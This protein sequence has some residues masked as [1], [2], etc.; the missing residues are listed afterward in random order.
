MIR[1]PIVIFD[2]DGTLIDSAFDIA[3]SIN[4]VRGT[5]GLS[6]LTQQQIVEAINGT[7][8]NLAHY[9]Y[10][11]STYE[12]KH[13]ALFETHYHEQCIQNVALYSH[14]DALLQHLSVKKVRCSVA[15]NAP[16]SFA[17]RMLGH[18]GVVHH[19]DYILGAD[20]YRAKPHPDMLHTIL[21]NYRYDKDQDPMPIM[22]GDNTKD[23]QAALNAGIK[24]LHV[25]WG[26]TTI[27]YEVKLTSPLELL[28]HLY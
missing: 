21:S 27:P 8:E 20:T 28:D 18:L 15:T 10:E 13:R 22:V 19:F 23:I 4:Y 7:Q 12:P 25:T 16:A 2:M 11:T 1:Q 3:V 26:F 5:F 14:I 17:K 24:P 9:F 6:P